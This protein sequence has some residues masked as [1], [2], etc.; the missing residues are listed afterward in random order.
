MWKIFSACNG[1][2][3]PIKRQ[4]LAEQTKKYDPNICYL[5]KIHFRGNHISRL[6]AERW[7]IDTS[8]KDYSKESRS[9]YIN[10]R[11]R[12]LQSK[13]NYQR[14]TKGIIQSLKGQSPEKT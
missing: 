2:N 13:E 6:E 14:Q 4:R 5:Q 11:K 3:T 10:I 9:G 12:R 8:C 1:L 7:K